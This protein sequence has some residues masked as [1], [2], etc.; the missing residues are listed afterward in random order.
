[1]MLPAS[2]LPPPVGDSMPARGD[3]FLDFDELAEEVSSLPERL[4]I[5]LSLR[6]EQ[7]CSCEE[8]GA[9][10]D[11]APLKVEKMIQRALSRLN[12]LACL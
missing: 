1:M 9:I 6:Y 12:V 10:L 7:D 2:S 4:Q 8:I 11:I 5:I 3:T